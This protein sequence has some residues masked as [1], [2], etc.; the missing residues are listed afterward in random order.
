LNLP[1]NKGIEA[2]GL[3]FGDFDR[4]KVVFVPVGSFECHSKMLPLGTDTYISIAFSR[5]FASAI[6]GLV[7][8]PV[9]YSTCPRTAHLEGTVSVSAGSFKAYLEEICISLRRHGFRKGV[10]VNIHSGCDAILKVLVGELFERKGIRVFYVDPYRSGDGRIFE[11]KSNSYKECSLLLAALKILGE[12]N[13]LKMVD[14]SRVDEKTS[15]SREIEQIRKYGTVGFE[16]EN[17]ADHVAGAKD[18]DINKGLAFYRDQAERF[19]HLLPSLEKYWKGGST[20][21]SG[22]NAMS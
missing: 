14:A 17:P 12:E 22:E 20:R 6:N 7:L 10:I 18:A 21:R 9:C 1:H 3:T 2:C 11:G 16:Y 5:L 15:R 19:A 8:P 4:R 13:I